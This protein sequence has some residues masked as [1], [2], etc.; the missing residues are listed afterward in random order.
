VRHPGA[1]TEAA[2]R[3]GVSK[4]AEAEKESHSK[5]AHIRGRGL[6]GL[7]FMKKEI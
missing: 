5:N 3:H 7:R 1:L 6:L 2:S 4:M